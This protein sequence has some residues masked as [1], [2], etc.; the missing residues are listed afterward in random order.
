MNQARPKR[1]RQRAAAKAAKNFAESDRI[2]DALAAQGI[3]PKDGPS[4]TTWVKA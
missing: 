4:G 1:T 3:V 2:R